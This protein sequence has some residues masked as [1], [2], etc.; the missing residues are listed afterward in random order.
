MSNPN[1]PQLFLHKVRKQVLKT[2]RIDY[3][4]KYYTFEGLE[5]SDCMFLNNFLTAIRKKR[6]SA[7]FTL[8]FFGP[9]DYS[10]EGGIKYSLFK[11][12]GVVCDCRDTVFV[13]PHDWLCQYDPTIPIFIKKDGFRYLDLE[14]QECSDTLAYLI[15]D[16]FHISS[17]I[18]FPLPGLPGC[19]SIGKCDEDWCITYLNIQQTYTSDFHRLYFWS[20]L[21]IENIDFSEFDAKVEADDLDCPVRH[22]QGIKIKN[23]PQFGIVN[24]YW[25]S[26]KTPA[27]FCIDCRKD[28][29][30]IEVSVDLNKNGINLYFINPIIMKR[31]SN[32]IMSNVEGFIELLKS[33]F[34]IPKALLTY[35]Y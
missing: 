15:R 8:D 30:A 11:Y 26:D 22:N 35:F 13:L 34:S 19:F 29:R 21:L 20:F 1:K 9:R 6:E 33:V 3:V 27:C 2:R 16:R 17:P 10:W 4:F 7:S 32:A 25:Y 24:Y 28:Y 12:I 23:N 18:R 31:K 14:K 5:H